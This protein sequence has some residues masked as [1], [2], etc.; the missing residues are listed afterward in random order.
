MESSASMAH[1]W[2]AQS[3]Y[4][5]VC[6][7]QRHCEASRHVGT[8]VSRAPP[9]QQ[10]PLGAVSSGGTCNLRPSLCQRVR[11]GFSRSL[12]R[13]RGGDRRSAH[14]FT[15]KLRAAPLITYD[16]VKMQVT[17]YEFTLQLAPARQS[18]KKWGCLSMNGMYFYLGAWFRNKSET[19]RW[20]IATEDWERE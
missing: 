14:S 7:S 16:L 12:S 5:G 20:V 13:Q 11:I 6:W 8:S 19:E 17:P 15:P 1:W 10:H 4:A 18:E 9:R 3:D 2:T